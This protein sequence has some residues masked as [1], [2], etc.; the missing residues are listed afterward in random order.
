MLL[1]HPANGRHEHDLPVAQTEV[2]VPA[3][4]TSAVDQ[5]RAQMS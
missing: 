3:G 4:A 2:T 5:R 1:A